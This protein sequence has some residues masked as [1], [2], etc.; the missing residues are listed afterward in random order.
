MDAVDGDS[1]NKKDSLFEDLVP[2]ISL[3]SQSGHRRIEDQSSLNCPSSAGRMK[4][5]IVQK[6][7]KFT[8]IN[9]A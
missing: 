1:H 8:N 4:H 6:S 2:L 5:H 9:H 7:Y 3:G